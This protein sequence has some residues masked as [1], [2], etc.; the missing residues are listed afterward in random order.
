[1]RLLLLGKKA[2]RP[3]SSASQEKLEKCFF[4]ALAL[5]VGTV[6]PALK[7]QGIPAWD[8]VGHMR[9]VAAL[10]SAFDVMLTTD[11]ILELSDFSKACEIL[12]VHGIDVGH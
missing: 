3:M 1:M 10:E 5:P 9:L 4:E 2:R 8:S 11:Q 6:V 12:R 7:Y